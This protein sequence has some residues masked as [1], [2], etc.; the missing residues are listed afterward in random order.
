M[1]IGVVMG[2]LPTTTAVHLLITVLALAMLLLAVL[3][4]VIAITPHRLSRHQLNMGQ[5][6]LTVWAFSS[7]S[8]ALPKFS[9]GGLLNTMLRLLLLLPLLHQDTKSSNKAIM[10]GHDIIVSSS[11]FFCCN[12]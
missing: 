11:L 5:V 4:A 1:T 3:V 10:N 2:V 8:Q 9:L 6:Y 12:S 7:S